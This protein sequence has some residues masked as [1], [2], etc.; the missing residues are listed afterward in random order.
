[1]KICIVT[2]TLF[3]E[4]GGPSIFVDNFVKSLRKDGHQVTVVAISHGRG[5]KNYEEGCSI[6]R[7]GRKG[8]RIFRVLKTI[9]TIIKYGKRNDVLYSC[10]LFLESAISK[11]MIRKPLIIRAGGDPVWERWINQQGFKS[12]LTEFQRKKYSLRIEFKKFLQRLSYRAADRVITNSY[13]FGSIVRGWGIP[14]AKITVV[15]SGVDLEN[16]KFPEREEIKNRLSLQGK[17]VILTVGRLIGLKRIDEII[18]AFSELKNDDCHLWIIGEGPQKESL[19]GLSQRLHLSEKIKFLGIK[20]HEEVMQYLRAA[21][22]F[23]LN[24]ASEVMPNVVLES[25]AVGTPVIAPNVGGIPEIIQNEVDG[26]LY[27]LKKEN[28]LELREAVERLLR[29][30]DLKRQI[31]QNGF[32]K[33]DQFRWEKAHETNLRVM[34]SIR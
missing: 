6:I 29:D 19:I 17:K 5:S 22:L 10:G 9:I 1:M 14:E 21:D 26:L 13:F 3:P 16:I 12:D 24:S 34:N 31:I 28:V 8:S 11:W 25:L 20:G 30:D 4:P 32:L 2:P 33:A 7:I 23:V 18:R 27:P 15:Y